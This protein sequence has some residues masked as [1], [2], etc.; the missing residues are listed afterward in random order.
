MSPLAPKIEETSSVL[1]AFLLLFF[2]FSILNLHQ[3]LFSHIFSPLLLIIS[4]I[5]SSS[6][7]VT[8][9]AHAPSSSSLSLS[10][11]NLKDI[12]Q[13]KIIILF[14]SII[15]NY[16]YASPCSFKEK[17]KAIACYNIYILYKNKIYMNV[18]IPK[19]VK[20]IC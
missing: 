2:F 12:T 17:F 3:A 14:Y 5:S 16:N 10:L 9:S 18:S 6:S 15:V 7:L 13:V 11:S 1:W 19:L 20:N 4:F 8:Q